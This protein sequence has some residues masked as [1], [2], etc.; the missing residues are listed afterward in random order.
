MIYTPYQH[1]KEHIIA[2]NPDNYRDAMDAV[3]KLTDSARELAGSDKQELD[4]INALHNEIMS[5]LPV[6]TMKN[7]DWNDYDHAMRLA[8]TRVT[9][10]ANKM[11]TVIMLS[12]DPV[13]EHIT[14]FNKTTGETRQYKPENLIPTDVIYRP[15]KKTKYT[16]E[17]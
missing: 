6:P 17:H 15:V 3:Q 2:Y 5:N 14:A 8:Y 4:H 12:Y 1:S 11:A 16:A 10:N 7:I 13:V 9:A